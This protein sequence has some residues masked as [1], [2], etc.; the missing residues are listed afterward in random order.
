MTKFKQHMEMSNVKKQIRERLFGDRKSEEQPKVEPTRVEPALPKQS[1]TASSPSL[2]YLAYV[3]LGIAAFIS[4]VAAYFSIIGLTEIFYAAFWPVAIM[5]AALELGKVVAAVWTHQNW[6]TF[7][8]YIKLPLVLILVGLMFVTSLGIF[9]LLAK[10]HSAQEFPI[11]QVEEKVSNYNSQIEFHK[12]RVGIF[13][14]Q[15]SSLNEAMGKYTELGAVSKGIDRTQE[16]VDNIQDKIDKENIKIEDLQN[17]ILEAK[18]S[19]AS[20]EAKLGPLN[21]IAKLIG[22]GES[23]ENAVVIVILIIIFCFDPLALLLIILSYQ[24]IK[25]STRRPTI[26]GTRHLKEEVLELLI[27]GGYGFNKVDI[28]KMSKEGLVKVANILR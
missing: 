8:Y 7:K 4:V 5:G 12:E 27:Q 23:L 15:L 9:G 21:Y 6:H 17:K 13:R 22:A 3:T 26:D 18:Q 24:H 10:G 11:A 2:L 1:Y 16:R 14:T 19:V 20:I 25:E 28:E